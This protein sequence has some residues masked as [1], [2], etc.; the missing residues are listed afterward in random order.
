MTAPAP[1]GATGGPDPA[2]VG[3]PTPPSGRRGGLVA[4]VVVLAVVALAAV[5]VAS[6]RAA[7]GDIDLSDARAGES[8]GQAAAVYVDL[9]PTADDTLTGASS[10]AAVEVSLH[11]AEVT[12][13]LA[14]MELTDAMALPGGETTELRPGG[15]HLMLENLRE[16]LEPGDR[17]EVTLEFDRAG[18]RTIEV[19]VV[20]LAQLME[21]P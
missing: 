17:I 20:G 21:Q 7:P 10:P 18:E 4:V 2:A 11:E 5:L 3:D 8:T 16:P 12:D 19:P 1:T 14:I 6:R 15:S 13:G 9:R